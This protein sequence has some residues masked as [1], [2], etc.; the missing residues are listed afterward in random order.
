MKLQ[1]LQFVH[2]VVKNK[3]NISVA[4]Q[5]L[6]TSQP[7]ISKQIRLFEE[8]LGIE[9]FYRNSNRLL[10]ITQAGQ[11]IIRSIEKI[12]FEIR[13]LKKTAE[14]KAHHH[15]GTLA[16]ATTHT[17]ARYALPEIIKKFKTRYPHVKIHIHQGNPTE[18]SRMVLQ[19]VADIAIA[20]EAVSATE[21]LISFACYQWNRVV[22]TLPGHPLTRLNRPLQL[23]DIATYPLITYDFAFAG[24]SVVNKVFEQEGLKPN[25]VLTAIDSDVIKTY[26]KLDL[27]I[28]LLANMAYSAQEDKDLVAID[29]AHLFPD[30]TTSIGLRR[31][32][33]VR[34]FAYHFIELFAP[35]LNR[36]QI[37]QQME[38]HTA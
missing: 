20:T 34:Q 22:L 24:R 10:G 8:E 25:V 12:L 31:G 9:I 13:N 30:S 5:K 3:L 18:I 35:H 29:A 37:I 15:E 16:I 4:A 11:E 7:G 17:Q 28:G 32:G 27:G 14:D 26:V 1:Q 23:A 38:C 6:H 19:G 21:G 36:E 2:A 33:F